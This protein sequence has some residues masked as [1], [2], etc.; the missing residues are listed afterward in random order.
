M[1]NYKNTWNDTISVHKK[2][3]TIGKKKISNYNLMQNII[4][5]KFVPIYMVHSLKN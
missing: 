2:K 3:K 1:K 5:A 4:I